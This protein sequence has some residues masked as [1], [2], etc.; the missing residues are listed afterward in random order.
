MSCGASDG[1]HAGKHDEVRV[2][3]DDPRHHREEVR[4]PR[5]VGVFGGED[6]EAEHVGRVHSFGA[7]VERVGLVPRHERDGLDPVLLHQPLVDDRPRLVGGD[8]AEHGVAAGRGV[9][10]LV[11]RV[12][13]VHRPGLLHD[14]NDGLGGGVDVRSDDV[15]DAVAGQLA[16]AV[17][18]QLRVVLVVDR[19]DLDHVLLTVDLDPAHGVVHLGG[20]FR[21]VAID[22]APGG[23]G[24][25]HDPEDADIE[26]PGSLGRAGREQGCAEGQSAGRCRRGGDSSN[27]LHQVDSQLLVLGRITFRNG[28]GPARRS[29]S[30]DRPCAP[31]LQQCSCRNA[32]T[33]G[34][35]PQVRE[36]PVTTF[37]GAR[38]GIAPAARRD[39]CGRNVSHPDGAKPLPIAPSRRERRR[40]YARVP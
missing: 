30:C 29:I 38:P 13:E 23:G 27:R 5:L 15:A 17:D 21:A 36:P 8:H 12:G 39:R 11:E 16:G 4:R 9:E 32:A 14:G 25:A 18:G 2:E 22:E 19:R 33:C 34:L 24:A 28:S 31:D 6:L 37:L 26:G 1:A 10:R 7:L 20:D 3:L 40:E 35:C